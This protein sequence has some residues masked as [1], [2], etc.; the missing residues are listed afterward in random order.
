MAKIL[1]IA[2][3]FFC[4]GILVFPQENFYAKTTEMSCCANKTE[5]KDCCKT[6]KKTP[7]HDSKSKNKSCDGN[8]NSC[9]VCCSS[10]HFSAVIY[11]PTQEISTEFSISEKADHSYVDPYFSVP[12]HSIWQP[13]KIG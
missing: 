6:D 8:C 1:K 9:Q 7:C 11:S 4:M 13:P 10:Y 5:K 2:L 3:M 12:F